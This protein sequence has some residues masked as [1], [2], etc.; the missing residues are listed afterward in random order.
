MVQLKLENFEQVVADAS[1]ALE[2]DSN[3][4]KAYHRRGKAYMA[5]GE[6]SKAKWDFKSCLDRKIRD[7]DIMACIE[8]V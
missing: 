7:P 6:Y 1:K 3:Y 8:V 2:I 4:V 5:L